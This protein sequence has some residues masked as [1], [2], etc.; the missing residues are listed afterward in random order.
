MRDF[1][2]V[3]TGGIPLSIEPRREFA[4]ACQRVSDAA[5]AYIG[6]A[7]LAGHDVQIGEREVVVTMDGAK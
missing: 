5:H 6:A 7:L 3:Q 2:V 1:V 4:D